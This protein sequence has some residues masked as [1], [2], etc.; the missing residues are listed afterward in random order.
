MYLTKIKSFIRQLTPPIL[1][2]SLR[3]LYLLGVGKTNPSS[4]N[5][6]NEVE[7]KL[8]SAFVAL[9]KGTTQNEIVL[10]DRLK[11]KI[12]PDSRFAFEYFCFRSPGMVEELNTFIRLTQDRFRLLD[13]GALHGIFSL[14]FTKQR[15]ESLAIA[16]DASPIAFARCLYNIYNNSSDRIIPVECALSEQ[17]AGVLNMHYAWEHAVA[18]G[19]NIEDSK[20]EHLTVTTMTGDSLCRHHSFIPDVIKIDVEGHEV[21]VLRGLQAT[22]SQATPLIFLELHPERI[23][24][25]GNSVEDVIKFF[26][27]LKYEASCALT[28]VHIPLEQLSNVKIDQHL[29]LQRQ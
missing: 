9:N 23:S 3:Y 19:T 18:S 13:I 24:Q 17:D 20:Q 1:W 14:V 25:E 27:D 4:G 28:G 22:I 21:K 5:Q 8:K 26:L 12:H 15:P 2:S 6:L 29:V 11:L 16:V 7:T 10:R